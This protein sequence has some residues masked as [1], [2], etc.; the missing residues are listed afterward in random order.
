MASTVGALMPPARLP[1]ALALGA[2]EHL[3]AWRVIGMRD[4]RYAQARSRPA[5]SQMNVGW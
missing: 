1:P 2:A 5:S 4:T 3:A